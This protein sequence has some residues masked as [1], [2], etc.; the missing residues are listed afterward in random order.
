M[1]IKRSQSSLCVRCAEHQRKYTE[2]R[3]EMAQS[4]SSAE[5]RLMQVIHQKLA[6]LA[7]CIEQ[8]RR[9]SVRPQQ[10]VLHF[11]SESKSCLS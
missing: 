2:C 10:E 8:H 6:C 9:L 11:V 7:D 3:D 4:V 1:N 5:E